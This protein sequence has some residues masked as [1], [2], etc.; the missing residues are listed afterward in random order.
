MES[1]QNKTSEFVPRR[2]L[3]GGHLQT[4]ASFLI[5]RHF[6]VPPAE[7]RLVEVEP[8]IR[9]LCHC[10]WQ[11]ERQDKLTV[12]IVHGLEGS[13]E[14][15]YAI[16]IAQK[17][18]ALGMNVIR[19]NQRNCGGTDSLSPTLYHSGRSHDLAAIAKH[20]IEQDGIQRFAFVGY[21][22]G[23]NLVLKLAGEW[24]T[25]APAQ[26][27]AVAAV[28]PAMDLGA[29]ADAL[30]L[31]SNRLY[32]LYFLRKL[33]ER[34]RAKARLFPDIFDI[35]RLNGIRSLRDFDEQITAHYSGFAGADDYYTRSAAANVVD[36]IS[37]PALIIHAANDPF[38]RILPGTRKKLMANANITFIEATDGGHCS[39]IADP[40]G[41]DGHWA[42]QKVVE[43]LRQ[44]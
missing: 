9:V 20:F 15:G 29:S 22:M 3:R 27:R 38:I 2:G 39:F 10:N 40:N 41:Y 24:S 16:G 23:G 37:K 13:S 21:S 14:S 32:E 26:F 33:R 35:A 17:G 30:H 34:M 42:E 28:C 18:L 7:E 25:Q 36:R 4:L 44:F 6:A 5:R 11:P 1:T 12:I 31:K 8:G 19:M 43:F